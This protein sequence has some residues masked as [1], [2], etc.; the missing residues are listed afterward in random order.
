MQGLY[1]YEKYCVIYSD[2][3]NICNISVLISFTFMQYEQK[4]V[5]IIVK[6]ICLIK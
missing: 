6:T 2:K 1:F 4:Y 5:K 3:I